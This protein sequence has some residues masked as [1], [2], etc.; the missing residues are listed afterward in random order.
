MPKTLDSTEIKAFIRS[1]NFITFKKENTHPHKN[2]N[3]QSLITALIIA[4]SV[5][6]IKVHTNTKAQVDAHSFTDIDAYGSSSYGS[7]GLGTGDNGYS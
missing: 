3:M 2:K 7:D 6:A 4:S 5:N 1:L